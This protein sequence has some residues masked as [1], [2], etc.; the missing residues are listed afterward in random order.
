MA[1]I[2][3]RDRRRSSRSSGAAAAPLGRRPDAENPLAR[4]VPFSSLV[5][6]HDVITRGGDYLRTWRLDGVPFECAD[7]HAHR[8]APRG[9]LQPASQPGRRPVGRLVA[10]AAPGR[11]RHHERARATGFARELSRAYYAK[12]DGQ[13]LMSNELYLTLVY[14]PN[15][16]RVSRALQST[17]RSRAAI[18]TGPGRRPAGDGG[19][20]RARRARPAR[21]RPAAARHPRDERGRDYSELAEFLGYL[22][23]GT[24]RAIPQTAGPLYRIAADDTPVLRRR[25]AGAAPRRRAPLRRPR[26]PARIRRRGRARAS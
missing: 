24:W 15:A 13:R 26:R 21:I 4:F 6:A 20:E 11:R 23:N 14:R 18:A 17:Q 22:V 7:D 10:P 1:C 12:L 25:Q 19:D 8:R 5:S 9:P 2:T 3:R 16:S